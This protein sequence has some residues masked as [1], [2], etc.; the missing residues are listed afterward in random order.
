MTR[1][2]PE[3]RGKTDD[4]RAP[5]RVR[6]RV[7]ERAGGC[8]HKCG[9]KIA[10]GEAWTLEHLLALIN[11]GENRE[12]NLDVTCGFCLPAKNAEDMAI[13]AKNARVAKKHRG[14]AKPKRK[15]PYRRFDGTPVYP[16]RKET[17][18]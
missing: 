16:D 11:G 6:L 17:H 18:Q 5:D 14:L 1:S 4:T 15:M 7:F 8:C 13:K 2:V 9:R 10:A 12:A 3:W